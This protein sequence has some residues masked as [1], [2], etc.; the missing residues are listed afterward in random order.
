VSELTRTET[1]ADCTARTH[2][3]RELMAA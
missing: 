2:V 1:L 3:G